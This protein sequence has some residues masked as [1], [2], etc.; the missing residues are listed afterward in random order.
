MAEI[1]K[2]KKFKPAVKKL[3]FA[4]TAV[5]NADIEEFVRIKNTEHI[6]KK[7]FNVE[8]YSWEDI[9][10]LIDENK[11]THDWYVKNQNYKTQKSVSITFQD[12]TEEITCIPKFKRVHTSYIQ[13]IVPLHGSFSSPMLEEVFRHA[14]VI[15][16]L[17]ST[18]LPVSSTTINL[19]YFSLQIQI[20][21]TGLDPI[22]KY[23]VLLTF[24][25]NILDL[26]S[27]NKKYTGIIIKPHYPSFTTYFYKNENKVEITSREEILVGDDALLSDEIFIKT[28]PE[29]TKIE[30]NWKLLSKDFKDK[31]TLIINVEPFIEQQ[32][33][34]ILV[35]DPLKVRQVSGPL[36]EFIIDSIEEE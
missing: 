16:E 4:T 29:K 17:K 5:K 27:T 23:K 33:K 24:T 13:K 3:Y 32:Y 35:E 34:S 15:R 9:V 6:K 21:N 14:E 12:G 28:K 25:G 36:E 30:V 20:H 31:G 11:R 19:S 1:E 2:V 18:L 7:L 22:E 26:N 8:I 10:D